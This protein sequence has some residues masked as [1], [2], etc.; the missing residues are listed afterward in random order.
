MTDGRAQGVNLGSA[1]ATLGFARI[2]ANRG[3]CLEAFRLARQALA[4]AGADGRVRRHASSLLNSLIPSYHLPILNDEHR[5][6]AWDAALRKAIRPGDL[7]LEIGSGPGV[8]T[9]QATYLRRP[10]AT[11]APTAVRSAQI[12][13]P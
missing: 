9:T 8:T 4:L 1:E 10:L 3:H 12:V 13:A 5:T 7:V 6:A 2:A 11:A